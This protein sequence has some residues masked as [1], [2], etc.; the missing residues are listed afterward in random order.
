MEFTKIL[1]QRLTFK[2][3]KRSKNRTPPPPAGPGRRSRSTPPGVPG[4]G[5]ERQAK[6]SSKSCRN[7]RFRQFR[8][9]A[10][11][12]SSRIL[13]IRNTDLMHSNET[14][15]SGLSD[16]PR[17]FTVPSLMVIH[18]SVSLSPEEQV[19]FECIRSV[20]GGDSDQ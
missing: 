11:R 20:Q 8:H 7:V 4:R 19:S 9:V 2:S 3:S 14:C 16:T 18:H 6:H 13:T 12:G 17:G 1:N 5:A 10:A 15:S